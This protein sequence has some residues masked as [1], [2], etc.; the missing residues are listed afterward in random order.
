MFVSGGAG[1]ALG[2]LI[3]SETQ[4]PRTYPTRVAQRGGG[5]K[6]HGRHRRSGIALSNHSTNSA[7]QRRLKCISDPVED[8]S[9]HVSV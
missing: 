2:G 7:C 8:L 3:A 6:T 5:A 4:R 1:G 9:K